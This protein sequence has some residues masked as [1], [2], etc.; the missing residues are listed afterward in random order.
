MKYHYATR[1]EL[2]AD[3]HLH[4]FYE[5]FVQKP[6]SSK[7]LNVGLFPT[8]VEFTYRGKAFSTINMLQLLS[9][10]DPKLHSTIRFPKIP[11]DWYKHS[12]LDKTQ[13]VKCT[14]QLVSVQKA[15]H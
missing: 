7:F 11:S 5:V 8:E 4:P 13:F 3:G 10:M 2:L 15:K 14:K 1:L 9:N 12:K 6:R